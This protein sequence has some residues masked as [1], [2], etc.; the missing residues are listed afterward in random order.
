MQTNQ[1]NQHIP[2]PGTENNLKNWDVLKQTVDGRF[3]SRENGVLRIL[4]PPDK[5][6]EFIVY[7]DQTLVNIPSAFGYPAIYPLPD[8]TFEKP[9]RAVLMDLDGTSVHSESFWMWIIEAVTKK[10][11]G[12]R[13][14]RLEPEDE[15]F[16][17][18]NSVSEHLQ[19]CINKY[20]PDATI[21]QARNL[22]FEI[23]DYEMNEIMKGRG[24]KDAFEPAP[25]LKNFLL[26]LKNAHIKIGLVTSGLYQKAWPEILSAFQQ[27]GLGNPADFY[28]AIITAGSRIIKGNPGTMGELC[29]KPHPWLYAEAAKVGLGLGK[30]DDRHVIGI[31]DSAAGVLSIRL[32]GYQA[33][34]IEGGN[35]MK[36]E[37]SSLLLK[38]CVD[39][40]SV[41][42]VII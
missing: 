21:D 42:E 25:G 19:Y 1:S 31:E 9:A 17:S 7:R 18:G 35:I 29:A 16:I 4:S 10:L 20:C 36:S 22:Y 27:M 13:N 24:K 15:P 33:L 32:A 8:T 34:G 37:M 14:F 11:S 40:N 39:L 38:S 41:T 5:K 26:E 12:D 23:T 6:S 30:E 3:K 28:D 2:V